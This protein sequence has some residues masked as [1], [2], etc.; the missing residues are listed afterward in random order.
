VARTVKRPALRLVVA[1]GLMR[2]ALE[3]IRASFPR[4]D[5]EYCPDGAALCR[6]V[7]RLKPTVAFVTKDPVGINTNSR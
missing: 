4:I 5:A 7:D 3:Q 1:G 6:V 2:G